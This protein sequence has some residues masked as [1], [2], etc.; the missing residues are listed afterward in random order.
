MDRVASF[1]A[2]KTPRRLLAIALFVALIVLFR[3][4]APLLIFFVAFE[5]SFGFLRDQLHKYTKLS[6]KVSLAIVLV[7]F[8]ALIATGVALGVGR[9]V[10]E[11]AHTHQSF[12]ERIAAVREHPLYERVREHVGDTDKV[13]D[14][15]KHYAG[16]AM[17]AASAIGHFLI[18]ALVG[19]ILA[20]VFLLEEHEIK[21]F[22][23][24]I[25]PR[26]LHGTLLRWFGHVADATVVTL[27]LQLIVAACNTL[28]TLPVLLIL[29][30]PHIGPLM[31][32]I[33]VS[34]LV[35]VVG[36]VVSGA[37]LSLLAYQA[38][39][40]VGVGVFLVLTFILHK[41][42]SYYLNP[43][44]TARHVRLPGF[45]LIIS[46]LLWEHLL[47]FVGLFVSFP[48]LFVAGRIR[49]EMLEEEGKLADAK[50][51]ALPK[52]AEGPHEIE[53]KT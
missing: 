13:V 6:K 19:L 41:I 12:P 11:F 46:L 16:S 15:A 43:R 26:S 24:K 2:E 27:Q 33:F 5:R 44:L 7:A 37:V 23:Q 3:H 21:G 38:K 35:P 10:H 47:G 42:E 8:F 9:A 39:G 17:S 53:K 22:Y 4:L 51:A 48:V 40:W 32:L 29:G 34:A 25:S 52:K 30:I 49:A 45:L 31:L 20:I 50:L 36:N 28:M 14:G 18:H 1:F